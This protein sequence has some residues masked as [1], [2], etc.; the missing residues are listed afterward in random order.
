[1]QV[2]W[3]IFELIVPFLL[4]RLR[5]SELC[6][7]SRRLFDPAK[8]ISNDTEIIF[9]TT[10]SGIRHANFRIPWSKTEGSKGATIIL[11]DLNDPTSPIPALHHHLSAN[12]KVPAGSP[13]FAFETN[14]DGWEPLTKSN[15]L[16]RCN[17]V[18]T[19]AGLSALKAHAFRIGGCTELLLRGTNPDI[20][21][22]QGRWKSR[23]FLEYWRKIQKILP[24][25]ISGSFS[26]S[27]IA[28]INSSMGSFKSK[29]GL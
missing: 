10:P 9:D 27:R 19:S 26:A 16:E 17:E 29:F 11:T 3:S 18:W 8:H 4:Y 20:V 15:W 22:V 13:L 14:D 24:L 12:A 2:H 28:L 6:V 1:L 21:C 5:S 25:F 23:A 7:P